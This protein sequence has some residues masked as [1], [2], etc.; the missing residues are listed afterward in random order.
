[1]KG[2]RLKDCG[3]VKGVWGFSL[4]LLVGYLLIFQLWMGADRQFIVSSGILW[5]LVFGVWL[6]V[7]WRNAYF[8]NRLDFLAH[9]GVVIDVLLEALLLVSHDHLGFWLCGL[10]FAIV[11]G[12]Y[13]ISI[14]R[15]IRG[16]R[17]QKL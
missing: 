5:G 3:T 6:M 1:M 13:R 8:V 2:T 7:S 16:A 4:G 14:L 12:G 15:R 10:G 17:S 11:I 9:W